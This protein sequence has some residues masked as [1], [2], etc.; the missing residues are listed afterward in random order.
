M[1]NKNL[2]MRLATSL[3]FIVFFLMLFFFGSYAWS[4][5]LFLLVIIGALPVGIREFALMGRKVGYRPSL[6][7]G[8]VAG[9]IIMLHFIIQGLWPAG[10]IL[11]L[12]LALSIAVAVTYFG[13]L[14]FEKD[15][16]SA[17]VSQALTLMS[18]LYMGLGLGFQ[19]KLLMV[20]AAVFPIFGWQLILALYLIVW[21]GDSAAYFLGNFFGRHKLA[22]AVSPK[23]TWEGAFGNLLGNLV[24]A[25]IIKVTI[26]NQ[27]HYMQWSSTRAISIALLLGVV[28]QLGDLVESSWKR[29]TNVK[30]SDVGGGIAIPGHGGLLDRID[31]LVLAAPAFCAYLYFLCGLK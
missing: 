16:S 25:F 5:V 2:I 8:T 14:F 9:W 27:S 30:D 19:I 15:L 31:S 13:A 10:D 6:C 21:L 18:A 26:F 28:G 23:K 7:V 22:P 20:K 3:V 11:P 12:W 17:L 24:A 1:D 29:S 4:K